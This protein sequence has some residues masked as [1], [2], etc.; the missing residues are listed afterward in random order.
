MHFFRVFI[1]MCTLSIYTRRRHRVHAV[2]SHREDVFLFALFFITSSRRTRE[3]ISR[4]LTR[5]GFFCIFLGGSRFRGIFFQPDV[6]MLPYIRSILLSMREYK[7]EKRTNQ[8]I[9]FTASFVEVLHCQKF[10]FGFF[11]M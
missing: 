6:K 8:F 9:T 5:F 11:W 7:G 2:H 3:E 10:P 1:P 4:I